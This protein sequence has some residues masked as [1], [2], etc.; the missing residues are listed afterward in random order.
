MNAFNIFWENGLW[1]NGNWYG[2]SFEFNGEVTNDFDK[3]IMF[4][5]MSW[6]GTASAHIWNIFD[7]TFLKPTLYSTALSSTP[8]SDSSLNPTGIPRETGTMVSGVSIDV[9]PLPEV[10]TYPTSPALGVGGGRV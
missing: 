2:S 5:G 8:I 7:N 3:Q 6:S 4:R 9:F 10:P 1:K